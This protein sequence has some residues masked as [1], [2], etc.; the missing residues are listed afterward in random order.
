M[1]QLIRSS[2]VPGL[3]CPVCDEYIPTSITVL[4][5]GVGLSCSSCGLHLEIDK[6]QSEKALKALA[7]LNEA[8]EQAERSRKFRK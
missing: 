5:S 3:S 4:L 7:G 1:E 6:K 8:H 2:R